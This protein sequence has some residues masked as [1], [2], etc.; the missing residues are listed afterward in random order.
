[1]NVPLKVLHL[2]LRPVAVVLGLM[3][4]NALGGSRRAPRGVLL[5]LAQFLA[6]PV[7]LT[8]ISF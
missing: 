5:G 6:F 2:L 1:L 4:L 8:F 3:E 7:D